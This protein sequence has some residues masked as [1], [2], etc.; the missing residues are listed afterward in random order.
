MQ[1]W[2]VVTL[3]P[4]KRFPE[5]GKRTIGVFQENE[6][7]NLAAALAY[8]AVFSLFPILMLLVA[9]L[10]FFFESS[11]AQAKVVA[12]L[13]NY[14]PGF[15]DLVQ[16]AVGQA[17]RA[18]GAVTI[19]GLVTLLWPASKVFTSLES[20]IARMWGV[21][22]QRGFVWSRVVAFLMVAGAGVLMIL[23]LIVSSLRS[24]LEGTTN[25]TLHFV[26]EMGLI[27][28][29]ADIIVS[30]VITAL[31]FVILYR[32]LPSTRVVFAD[33][34]PGALLA[35]FLWELAK[36]GFAFYLANF[37][38]F[39]AVYGSIGAVLAMM[40]WF[41]I[42]ALLV[43]LGAAFSSEYAKA[44]RAAPKQMVERR[45]AAGQTPPLLA[46]TAYEGA[47]NRVA[48]EYATVFTVAALLALA[49]YLGKK[50]LDSVTA[51]GGTSPRPASH[52]PH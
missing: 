4:W 38:N 10:S 13:T 15:G 20:F 39:N 12:S 9:G 50:I 1:N 23:T 22:K 45:W 31:V 18:R 34:W 51:K 35:A 42:T 24:F 3:L 28:Q 40:I 44:R 26:P 16:S 33:V 29:A 47:K 43:L 32:F 37:A 17:V 2:N 14:L 36:E 11:E 21:Q 25:E 30:L 41:W 52:R 19:I 46:G 5:V 7:M 48:G 49:T 6:G 8:Y 27:W